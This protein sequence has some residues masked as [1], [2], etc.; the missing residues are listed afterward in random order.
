MMKKALLRT[1]SFL[2]AAL[3]MILIFYFSAQDAAASTEQSMGVTEA[4]VSGYNDLFHKGWSAAQQLLYA[5]RLEHTVRKLAHF[6]EYFLLAGT[7]FF[8]LRSTEDHSIP[9]GN[10]SSDPCESAS[11][12][13]FATL[14][15]R[16]HF[17]AVMLICVLYA[18]SDEL[19]QHFLSGRS[20][21]LKDILIDS[22]GALCCYLLLAMV[23]RGRAHRIRAHRTREHRRR[24]QK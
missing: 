5:L 4:L 16:K 15:G 13:D 17:T 11:S 2:P 10:R 8:P 22:L 9:T 24:L 23:S 20:P 12:H 18:A 14:H 19:H 21:Q 7:L 6:S 3:V 1:L